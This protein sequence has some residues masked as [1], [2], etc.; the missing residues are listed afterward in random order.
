M[1]SL[2]VDAVIFN[3]LSDDLEVLLIRRG[4]PNE[5]FF[6]HWALVGGYVEKGERLEDA[7]RRE[8]REETGLDLRMPLDEIGIFDDPNRDPRGRVITIAYRTFVSRDRVAPQA[9]DDAKEVAWFSLRALPP[10]A[11]DHALIVEQ[12]RTMGYGKTF[13]NE[14]E[15]PDLH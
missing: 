11:F 13:Q 1:I 14:A 4:R 12:A 6:D 10:L 15:A 3:L 7:L 9:G 5:P 2:T 8:V